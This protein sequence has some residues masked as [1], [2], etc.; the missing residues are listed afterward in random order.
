[1]VVGDAFIAVEDLDDDKHSSSRLVV[2]VDV[3]EGVFA[4]GGD[5]DLEEQA[6]G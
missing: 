1:M 3:L 4:G 6:A 2:W 5:D